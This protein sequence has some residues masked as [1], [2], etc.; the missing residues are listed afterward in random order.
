MVLRD[1]VGGTVGLNNRTH[2]IDHKSSQA[3]FPGRLKA[4]VRSVWIEGKVGL[5]LR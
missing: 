2:Y 3:G 5:W 1:P 4:A